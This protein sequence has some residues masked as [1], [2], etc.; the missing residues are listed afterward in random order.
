VTMD[1]LLDRSFDWRKKR[2]YNGL[3]WII[4]RCNGPK[5]TTPIKMLLSRRWGKL[6]FTYKERGILHTRDTYFSP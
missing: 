1:E 4:L 2:T 3:R 5:T 6:S